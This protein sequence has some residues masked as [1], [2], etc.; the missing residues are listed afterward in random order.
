M[1]TYSHSLHVHVFV[2]VAACIYT[3][4]MKENTLLSKLTVVLGIPTPCVTLNSHLYA[5]GK[6]KFL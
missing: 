1:V 2:L 4:K 3:Y 5:Q 6:E